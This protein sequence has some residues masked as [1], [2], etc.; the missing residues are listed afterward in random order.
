[1]R[2]FVPLRLRTCTRCGHLECPCCRDFCDDIRCIDDDTYGATACS[3]ENACLYVEPIDSDGYVKLGEVTKTMKY[4]LR[5]WIVKGGLY[6]CEDGDDPT[7]EEVEAL[8]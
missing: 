1:M 3:L 7:D 8:R 5:E 4:P 6:L 2:A